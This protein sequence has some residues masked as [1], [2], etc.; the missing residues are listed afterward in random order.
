MKLLLIYAVTS[1][2][3]TSILLVAKRLGFRLRIR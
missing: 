3:L 1:L 2:L